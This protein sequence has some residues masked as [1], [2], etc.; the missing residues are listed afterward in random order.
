M[1]IRCLHRYLCLQVKTVSRISGCLSQ[2]VVRV[3]GTRNGNPNFRCLRQA[4]ANLEPVG[5]QTVIGMLITVE[6]DEIGMIQM[7]TP[8]IMTA[9]LFVVTIA[10][11]KLHLL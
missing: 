11:P 4:A 9:I 1:A 3:I 5:I 8:S 10:K 2:E 6:A 7:E